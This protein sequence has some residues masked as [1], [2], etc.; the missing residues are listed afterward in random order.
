MF[1]SGDP[2]M[3]EGYGAVG[4]I[5][6]VGNFD[7]CYSPNVSDMS[8]M[9]GQHLSSYD[10]ADDSVEPEIISLLSQANY[11]HNT[12]INGFRQAIQ[13]HNEIMIHCEYYYF[14]QIR[15]VKLANIQSAL[16]GAK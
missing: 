6:P 16:A 2:H 7:F 9:L 11:Q 10:D 13:S 8:E 5:F 14:L 1:C 4:V 3:A 12:S 15:D